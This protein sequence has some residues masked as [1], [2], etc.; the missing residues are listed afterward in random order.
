MKREHQI[1]FWHLI[2]AILAV[3]LPGAGVAAAIAIERG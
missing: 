1:S 3:I 2:V